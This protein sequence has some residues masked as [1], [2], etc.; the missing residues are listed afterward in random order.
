[1]YVS[2]AEVL[3]K[4]PPFTVN[5]SFN[6]ETIYAIILAFIFFDE[7]KEVKYLILYGIFFCCDLGCFTLDN[8]FKEKKQ[9]TS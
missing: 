7:S 6:L 8:F 5:L 9:I 1:L 4:I 2:F 3:K